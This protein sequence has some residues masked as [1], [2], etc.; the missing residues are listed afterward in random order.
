VSLGTF[1]P[2][3]ARSLH[4]SERAMPW[5]RCFR[6]VGFVRSLCR[7]CVP[8]SDF[9]AAISHVHRQQRSVGQESEETRAGRQRTVPSRARAFDVVDR[10]GGRGGPVAPRR[11][12]M[13]AMGDASFTGSAGFVGIGCGVSAW[14]AISPAPPPT[15]LHASSSIV[16][17][18]SFPSHPLERR[19][20]QGQRRRGGSCRQPAPVPRTTSLPSLLSR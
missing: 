4:P 2:F 15:R 7:R 14:Y 10:R 16:A 5:P 20:R 18:F 19:F 13:F 1:K 12:R 8:P 17:I 3:R 6:E 9:V 11:A